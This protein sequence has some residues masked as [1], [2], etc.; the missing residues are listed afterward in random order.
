MHSERLNYIKLEQRQRPLL[1]S[2]YSCEKT[3]QFLG[4]ALSEAA[5]LQKVETMLHRG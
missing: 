1:L 2:L 5:A 4:G 3:R